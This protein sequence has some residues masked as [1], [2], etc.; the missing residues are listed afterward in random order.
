M[1]FDFSEDQELLRDQAR[2]MLRERCSS[3][4]VRKV[5]DSDAALD[6]EL[7]RQIV[8]L[9]WTATALPEQY[10]GFGMGYLELCVLAEELGR[11]VAPVPFSS[12]VY[13]ATEA[14]LCAG[15]EEQKGRY[16][17]NLGNGT[18]IGTLAFAEGPGGVGADSIATRFDGETLTGTKVP[19]A[20]GSVATV[21]IVIARET[22]GALSMFLVDGD[23][24]YTQ[25]PVATIDER[26]RPQP[27]PLQKNTCATHGTGRRG[28]PNPSQRIRSR[29]RAVRVRAVRRHSSCFGHGR[30][31]CR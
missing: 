26:P 1:N 13:L 18:A 19:V 30:A 23:A 3:T 8:E 4:H 9:G 25:S 27:D 20:D 15:S 5:L 11:A 17:P 24:R 21:L 31:L 6:L 22:D 29:C 7:W 2:R 16:L 10:G 14:I 12:S 28:Q